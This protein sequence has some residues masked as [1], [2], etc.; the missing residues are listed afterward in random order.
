MVLENEYIKLRALEPDDLNI[1]YKWENN[2]NL[3]T[4]G[5]TL[6][7]YSKVALRQY[8]NETQMYDI[9]QNKQLRLM[10]D[11]QGDNE[12][13]GTVDLYDFDI[14]NGKAGVGI[15]IDELHRNK[16]YAFQ[17]LK[18]LQD[19]AFMFLRL[20]QLYAFISVNNHAS[21]HLFE[22]SGYSRVGIFK[23]WIQT[24]E[25]FVDVEVVQ[26]INKPK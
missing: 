8:I 9:Y 23:D 15:L 26:L 18:I 10:V 11:L 2:S 14:R 5:N 12:T 17:T 4:H 20:H 22:K 7:P 25:Q 6:S 1:L 19:Y 13:I 21:I 24:E 3:W 16:G